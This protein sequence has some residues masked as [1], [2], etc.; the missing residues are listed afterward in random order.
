MSTF[1]L[2]SAPNVL[3]QCEVHPSLVHKLRGVVSDLNA[4]L[5]M[6]SASDNALYLEVWIAYSDG[7]LDK[8]SC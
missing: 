2:S 3:H 7:L 8:H 6:N 5:T 4:M 1:R